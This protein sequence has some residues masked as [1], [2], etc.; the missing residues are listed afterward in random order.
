[1]IL[2][3]ISTEPNHNGNFVPKVPDRRLITENNEKPRISLSPTIDGCL[4][5]IPLGGAYLHQWYKSKDEI[6]TNCRFHNGYRK[7]KLFKVD[8]EKLKIPDAN[9][10]EPEDLIEC[11]FCEDA[12]ITKEHWITTEFKVPKEDQAIFTVE[13]FRFYR[14]E[15]GYPVIDMTNL[16]FIEGEIK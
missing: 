6:E 8:T 5:A 15:E 2:Y 3:H 10:Y 9:I 12:H 13:N 1:M 16:N 11:G 14:N 7:F 4:S